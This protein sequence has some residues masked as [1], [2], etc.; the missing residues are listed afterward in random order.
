M[1][2]FALISFF[3][4]GVSHSFAPKSFPTRSRSPTDSTSAPF[5]TSI[6]KTQSQ[7]QLSND[8]ENETFQEKLDR[9]LDTQFF[10]PDKLF[11]K[12]SQ[13]IND[14]PEKSMNPLVW[15][16]NLVRNDYETAEALFAAGFISFMV[17]I[18]QELLRMA[19]YGDAYQPFQN[20]S[21]PGSLF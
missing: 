12:E 10:D 18:S 9:I 15:F 16:A 5:H 8:P 11:E 17:V 6:T 1:K 4:I 14:N 3:L 21:A 13:E 19:R 20:G 2:S 7:L